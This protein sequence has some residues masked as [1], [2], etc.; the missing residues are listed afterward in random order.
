M[1]VDDGEGVMARMRAESPRAVVEVTLADA[2][3]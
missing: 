1:G 3:R 2:S